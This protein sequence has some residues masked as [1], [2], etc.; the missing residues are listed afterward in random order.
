MGSWW[1]GLYARHSAPEE[2]DKSPDMPWVHG[3]SGFTPDIPRLSAS[4]KLRRN[5]FFHLRRTHRAPMNEV[6]VQQNMLL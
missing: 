1:V 4:A 3:G 5:S 2:D 6:A